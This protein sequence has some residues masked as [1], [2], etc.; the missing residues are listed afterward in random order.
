MSE[1]K[2]R[3][4][5]PRFTGDNR[6]I[7]TIQATPET[8]SVGPRTFFCTAEDYSASGMRFPSESSVKS[9]TRI[10]LR[11]AVTKPPQAFRLL[12]EVV[13]CR[14]EPGRPGYAVGVRFVPGPGLT[15]DEW[16]AFV[17]KQDYLREGVQTG[18]L[19]P[20]RIPS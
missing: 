1:Q 8:E 4:K 19:D 9:G 15:L 6:L 7:A 16:A 11:L 10:Q 12:G 20:W 3:R 2:Y 13:W 5:E 14:Q 18:D 17:R